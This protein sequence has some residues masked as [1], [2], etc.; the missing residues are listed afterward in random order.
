MFA[1]VSVLPDSLSLNT[2]ASNSAAPDRARHGGITAAAFKLLIRVGYF[3]VDRL[4]SYSPCPNR[5]GLRT[6]ECLDW[7]VAACR[8]KRTCLR[9]SGGLNLIILLMIIDT[10]A[11]TS[12]HETGTVY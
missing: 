10:C 4:F 3:S 11:I 9:H 1:L 7:K 5:V 8:K 12:H 2:I 6:A